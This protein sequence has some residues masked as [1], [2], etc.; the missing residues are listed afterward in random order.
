VQATD[1]NRTFVR[2]LVDEVTMSNQLNWRFFHKQ[3]LMKGASH[4]I[5]SGCPT[6]VV[7]L[8]GIASYLDVLILG[9]PAAGTRSLALNPAFDRFPLLIRPSFGFTDV[10]YFS[11]AFLSQNRYTHLSILRDDNYN[12]DTFLS[13][14]IVLKVRTF[15]PTSFAST[16]LFPFSSQN[17]NLTAYTQLLKTAHD[18]TRGQPRRSLDPQAYTSL[19]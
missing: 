16:L 6:T 1:K 17:S 18:G 11:N 2:N 9:C 13:Q 15:N 7:S 5:F 8:Y 3:I 14:S 12:F 19:V 10:A 4:F